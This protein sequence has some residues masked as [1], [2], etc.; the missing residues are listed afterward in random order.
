ML[1]KGII[2]NFQF[3]IKLLRALKAVTGCT[4]PSFLRDG[5]VVRVKLMA[6]KFLRD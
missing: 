3:M 4:L 6:L 1:S 2:L 5:K